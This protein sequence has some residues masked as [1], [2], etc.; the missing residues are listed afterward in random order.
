MSQAALDLRTV[1]RACVVSAVREGE[2]LMGK[3]VEVT[4]NLD[5]GEQTVTV[6]E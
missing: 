3:L 6:V 2:P 4:R 1:F 5:T